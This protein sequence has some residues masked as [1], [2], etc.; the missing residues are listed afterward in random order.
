LLE[1]VLSLKHEELLQFL[2]GA[3]KHVSTTIF[4][5][6]P[7]DLVQELQEELV[8]IHA[9]P[10]EGYQNIERKIINRIKVL[11]HEGTINL[12]ETNERMFGGSVKN[13]DVIEA[14][15][16]TQSQSSIKRVAGW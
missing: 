11:S 2:K 10:R 1:V 5:K 8:Q 15:P 3:P 9:I 7:P 16:A 12:A 13:Y 6:S 4:S 14:G